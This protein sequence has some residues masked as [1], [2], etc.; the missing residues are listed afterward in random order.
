MKKILLI[1]AVAGLAMASC[2]KDR[3]CSCKEVVTETGNFPGATVTDYEYTILKE[4]RKTAYY[5]CT[6]KKQTYKIATETF[7]VDLNCSLK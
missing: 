4:S 7:D 2:K 1:V 5:A 6:H 3:V